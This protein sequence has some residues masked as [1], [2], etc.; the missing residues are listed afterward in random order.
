MSCAPRLISLSSS[1]NRKDRVSRESSVHSMISRNW[2]RM[3]SVR[4]M[5]QSLPAVRGPGLSGPADAADL[6]GPP[7]VR[8]TYRRTLPRGGSLLRD[9]AAGDA[10]A[11][12]AG[13][14]GLHVVGLG[15]NHERRAGAAEERVGA[16]AERHQLVRERL[17]RRAGLQHGEV[18]HV[19]GVRT[20][21]IHR[22]VLLAGD[23]NN[24]TV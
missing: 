11:G 16:V 3:K 23:M 21:R 10:I 7:Y 12:V 15:V 5:G 4:P 19:A 20:L 8:V 13:R 6:K 18:V 2:L 24:F 14:V 17:R 1:G 22:A 9:D